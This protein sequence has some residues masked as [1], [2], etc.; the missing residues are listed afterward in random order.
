MGTMENMARR[1]KR[2]LFI[3]DK[4]KPDC[5]KITISDKDIVN[6]SN[7][8]IISAVAF[9]NVKPMDTMTVIIQRKGSEK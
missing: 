1:A 6:V 7:G 4:S 2:M 5:I 9:D 3:P 8:W